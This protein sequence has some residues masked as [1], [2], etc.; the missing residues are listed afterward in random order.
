[1]PRQKD[2]IGRGWIGV[3]EKVI[4]RE[5]RVERGRIDKERRKRYA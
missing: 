1:L 5:W 2:S 4:S 3:K